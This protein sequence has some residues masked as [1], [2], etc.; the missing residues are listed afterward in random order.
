MAKDKLFKC[1]IWAIDEGGLLTEYIWCQ[2]A[3]ALEAMFENHIDGHLLYKWH[4]CSKFERDAWGAGY[5]EGYDIAVAVERITKDN[6]LRFQ[7]D[8]NQFDETFVC[9]ICSQNK[10]SFDNSGRTIYLGL[11]GS[12]WQI[13]NGC[14]DMV[15]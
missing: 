8:L 12:E 7:V 6:G 11:Y 1:E 5:E 13:C 9:G 3:A 15:D 14:K 10:S 2:N 4:E